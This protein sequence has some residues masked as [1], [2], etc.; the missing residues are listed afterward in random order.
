[1]N[2]RHHG[3]P[4]VHKGDPSLK[5]IV[6]ESGLSKSDLDYLVHLTAALSTAMIRNGWKTDS[7][8][9]FAPKLAKGLL[10]ELQNDKKD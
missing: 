3:D 10:R 9:E 8:I 1:M 6:I 2:F 4:S 7:I 5:Q